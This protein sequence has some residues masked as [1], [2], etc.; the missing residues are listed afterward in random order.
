MLN[1]SLVS[2][3]IPSDQV[4][5]KKLI[6]MKSLTTASSQVEVSGLDRVNKHIQ[7]SVLV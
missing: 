5:T 4:C 1:T 6:L 3:S 2:Y 7:S